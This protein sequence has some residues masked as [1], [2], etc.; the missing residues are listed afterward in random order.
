MVDPEQIE[1]ALEEMKAS[2][3]PYLAFVPTAEEIILHVSDGVSQI[4]V[5]IPLEATESV[6]A[7]LDM[8]IEEC[9]FILEEEFI[10]N[11]RWN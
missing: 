8:A 10:D 7:A 4:E 11:A 3:G 6:L 5:P 1:A 2:G 9:N